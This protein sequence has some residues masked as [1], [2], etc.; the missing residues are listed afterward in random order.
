[1]P[2]RHARAT[3]L[4]GRAALA[5]MAA[6][7]V[8]VAAE[9]IAQRLFRTTYSDVRL[10]GAPLT[11]RHWRVAGTAV[12]LANGAVAGILFRRSGLRGPR[13][14][15]LAAVAENTVLWPG[16]AI[17]DRVHPDRRSGVWPPLLWNGRVFA[18][19]TAVHALFGV[20]LGVLVRD[21]TPRR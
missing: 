14:G 6:A 20:V 15:M 19:E 13:D 16:M 8:W 21:D 5:G 2:T 3:E 1:M 4:D 10:L 17:M 7:A 11:R 9:P 18:Q 12:H